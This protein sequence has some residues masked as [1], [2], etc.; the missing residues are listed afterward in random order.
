MEDLPA[1]ITQLSAVV[2]QESTQFIDDL[3]LTSV[4]APLAVF[5]IVCFILRGGK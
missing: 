4:Y 1:E 2:A 5:T 3:G